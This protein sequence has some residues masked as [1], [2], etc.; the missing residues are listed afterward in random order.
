[1]TLRQI[2]FKVKRAGVALEY[3]FPKTIWVTITTSFNQEWDQSTTAQKASG[4]K[5]RRLW[6]TLPPTI[7]N[8][9]SHYQL[10]TKIKIGTRKLPCRLCHPFVLSLGFLW[11]TSLDICFIY[12]LTLMICKYLIH[13]FYVIF[14]FCSVF[15]LELIS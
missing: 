6:Q 2:F 9:G 15:T 5:V 13:H 8:Q 7:R 11:C 14:V 12:C 10:E 4:L 1:M 3:E